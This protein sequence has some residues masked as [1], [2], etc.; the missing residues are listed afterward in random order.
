MIPINELRIGNYIFI[1]GNIKRIS[2][3]SND[4]VFS[5]TPVL[6]ANGEQHEDVQS[7]NA[8]GVQP[9][10][11]TDLILTECGF[12]FHDYFRFWQYIDLSA[13]KRIELDIDSDYNIID[14]M[15]KPLVKKVNSLHQL[16]NIC[17]ALKGVELKFQHVQEVS[18]H[19]TGATI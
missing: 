12:V 17:F 19:F 7:F 8:E 11:L 4:V 6:W 5:E 14:F 3:I 15:R 1:H 13:S 9:V 10:L 18:R 2:L 16:Q